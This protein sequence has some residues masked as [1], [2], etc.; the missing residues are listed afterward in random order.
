MQYHSFIRANTLW[1][2]AWDFVSLSRKGRGPV[3]IE[4]LREFIE[5]GLSLNLSK[6]AKSLHVS[7][8]SL[9]KHIAALE[10]ECHAQ[11]INRSPTRIQL[12]VAGEAL[13]EEAYRLVAAH[14]NAV[15]R[16]KSL[17][18]VNRL[19]IGG[20]Y[21]SATILALVNQAVALV[22]AE[23]PVLAVSYQNHRH[24]SLRELLDANR[25][26]VAITILADGSE[27]R[28]GLAGMPLL[29]DPMICLV[30]DDHPFAQR[31]SISILELDNQTILKPVGS[32]STE[33]GRST[34]EKLFRRYNIQ[35]NEKPT[36][37]H[38]ISELT[39]VPN[40]DGLFIMERSML[41]TQP[42]SSHLK[43]V[44]LEEEDA[45]FTL[46]AVWHTD[47]K[48][49]DVDLFIHALEKVARP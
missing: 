28:E 29:H 47:A 31:E 49:P 32:H 16:I 26:D 18:H 24:N 44:R 41:D 37:V 2:A 46:Y 7:Q 8:P 20:L 5:V 12:T 22:N 11:L 3:N 38:S 34:V 13:F 48:N 9:S 36:F 43:V 39:T 23:E 21:E 35:P 10:Q 45:A 27:I 25:I 4:Y 40:D 19:R 14:D 6:A 15:A 30:G 17:K 33:H 42:Y 1:G